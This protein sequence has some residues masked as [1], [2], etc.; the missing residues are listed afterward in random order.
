MVYKDGEINLD[1]FIQK[2]QPDKNELAEILSKA[3][4]PFRTMLQF[5]E[6]CGV[7]ASTFSRILNQKITKPLSKDLIATIAK[8]GVSIDGQTN[9]TILLLE[10]LHASG[11]IDRESIEEKV[12]LAEINIERDERLFSLKNEMKNILSMSLL[13]RKH[14]IKYHAYIEDNNVNHILR[15][16]YSHE[17][18]VIELLEEFPEYCYFKLLATL[19]DGLFGELLEL[20]GAISYGRNYDSEAREI[21]TDTAIYYLENIWNPE[22]FSNVRTIFVFNDDLLYEGYHKLLLSR[23]V[24]TDFSIILVSQEKQDVIKE[25]HMKSNGESDY[26]FCDPPEHN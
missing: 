21:L 15:G 7:S 6:E 3:K 11:Y 19:P 10:L 25:W 14:G 20:E 9:E 18:F 5:S 12:R 16:F 22:S 23:E 8:H 2:R 17:E 26:L 24:N 1:N 4:G 13:K